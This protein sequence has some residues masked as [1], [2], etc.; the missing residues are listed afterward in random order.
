MEVRSFASG[1]LAAVHEAS[2]AKMMMKECLRQFIEFWLQLQFNYKDG[3]LYPKFG[4]KVIDLLQNQKITKIF[5][6]CILRIIFPIF[7][8]SFNSYAFL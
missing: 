6:C 1:T 3:V 7:G 2:V 5:N 4:F 8:V